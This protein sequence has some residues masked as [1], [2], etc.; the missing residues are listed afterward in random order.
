M[1]IYN[2][3][4]QLER[5]QFFS[6]TLGHPLVSTLPFLFIFFSS[7][8][9]LFTHLNVSISEAVIHSSTVYVLSL[10]LPLRQFLPVSNPVDTFFGL[11][12]QFLAEVF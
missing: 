5:K 9:S 12:T 7:F 6:L 10:I 2:W 4:P 3:A 1:Y 11:I 8:L